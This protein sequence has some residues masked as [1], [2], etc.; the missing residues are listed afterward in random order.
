[1]VKIKICGLTN[2]E[3]AKLAWGSGADLLGF[4]FAEGTKRFIELN[5]ASHIIRQLKSQYID[6][7]AV[8][9]FV[10]EALDDIA[11]A[12]AHCDLDHVQLHG[13]ETPKECSDLK[14]LV[15]KRYNRKIQIIKAFRVSDEIQPIESYGIGDYDAADYFVFDT[16]HPRLDGG[17]GKKFNWDV[18]K[19]EQGKIKKPF[20]LAG[21][22]VPSNIQEAIQQVRP[23]G[24]DVSSGIESE[25]RIK[26][27]KL[28]K[29]FID[30]A[31]NTKI[32]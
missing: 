23:Y 11:Y 5:D 8:G 2:L 27:E 21:G 15:E 24:I 25:P 26:D 17:T 13:R 22:L 6:V 19:R 18:L 4:I 1:M 9:L 3:D 31:R 28:L 7:I 14:E 30:N 16:F 29:E 12:V 10:K 20:F 32:T